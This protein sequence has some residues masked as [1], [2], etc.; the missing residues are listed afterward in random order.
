M[1]G[2]VVVCGILSKPTHSRFCFFLRR[3]FGSLFVSK[4]KKGVRRRKIGLRFYVSVATVLY[5][6]EL[7]FPSFCDC[8]VVVLTILRVLGFLWQVVSDFEAVVRSASHPCL[9]PA[10]VSVCL[11]SPPTFCTL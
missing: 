10:A 11:P 9:G 2:E 7:C 4:E 1:K 8:C 5:I 3:P 6:L